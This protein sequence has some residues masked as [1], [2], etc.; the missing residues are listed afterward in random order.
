MRMAIS[1]G[2]RNFDKFVYAR[3]GRSPYFL[4]CDSDDPQGT[5]DYQENP[6]LLGIDGAGIV[7]ADFVAKEKVDVLIT[8]RL[9]RNALKVIQAMNI[10]AYTAPETM[11][12]MEAIMAWKE[13]RLTQISESGA[14]S[15]KMDVLNNV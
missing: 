3:F 14:R 6:S 13:G 9:G 8:G 2:G 5:G 11:T 15:S 1:T 12:L 7:V 10:L 4:F